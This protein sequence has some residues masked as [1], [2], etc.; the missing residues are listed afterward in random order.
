MVVGFRVASMAS[1][2]VIGPS[3]A[4]MAANTL[5]QFV[6]AFLRLKEGFWC[7]SRAAGSGGGFFVLTFGRVSWA[8]GDVVGLFSFGLR[9]DFLCFV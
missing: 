6:P 5:V 7:W 8:A 4:L 3:A 1:G 2:R 9:G